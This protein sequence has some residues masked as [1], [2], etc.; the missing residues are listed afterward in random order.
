MTNVPCS[1]RS[2]GPSEG[3]QSCPTHCCPCQPLLNNIYSLPDSVQYRVL[4]VTVLKLLRA[5]GPVSHNT[6]LLEGRDLITASSC[7]LSPICQVTLKDSGYLTSEALEAAG[8]PV[9]MQTAG[10]LPQVSDSWPWRRLRTVLL[11][12]FQQRLML[13]FLGPHFENTD[14]GITVGSFSDSL[15]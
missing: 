4:D 8:G 1:D 5:R 12:G 9:R 3:S 11:A 13:L 2:F 14:L 15:S 10:P 7:R 6:Q